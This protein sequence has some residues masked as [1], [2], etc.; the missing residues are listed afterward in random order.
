MEER[1]GIGKDA[2]QATSSKD[3]CQ[4]KHVEDKRPRTDHSDTHN[5][6]AYVP[7]RG[8]FDIHSITQLES[9]FIQLKLGITNVSETSIDT[10]VLLDEQPLYWVV[11]KQLGKYSGP[12]PSMGRETSSP[13]C[14]RL[15]AS[16]SLAAF[17]RNLRPPSRFP[18]LCSRQH[19]F[20][21]V[22]HLEDSWHGIT[23]V[24]KSEA[25]YA[26]FE[27]IMEL[28]LLHC[29]LECF[30]EGPLIHASTKL[31]GRTAI[32]KSQL[33]VEVVR[34]TVCRTD[35]EESSSSQ[36]SK[37]GKSVDNRLN[38]VSYVI[39]RINFPPILLTDILWCNGLAVVRNP[40]DH[41]NLQTHPQDSP[42]TLCCLSISF[43]PLDSINTSQDT[44]RNV[45][46]LTQHPARQVGN[47]KKPYSGRSLGSLLSS[48]NLSSVWAAKR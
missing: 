3:K 6:R 12:Q 29:Y 17:L 2:E 24:A 25:A 36:E 26:S 16:E 46:E 28:Q 9:S 45:G 20:G 21:V 39:L 1:S 27:R 22:L 10:P 30:V 33:C 31:Y 34:S 40:Y 37:S 15:S 42:K 38:V 18:I 7:M 11:C 44:L 41:K 4:H 13:T 43:P 8:Q 47:D 19:N 23:I 35:G 32:G 48:C 5:P 14:A